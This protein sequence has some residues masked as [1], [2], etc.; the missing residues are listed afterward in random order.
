[1][2]DATKLDILGI[3]D[4]DLSH[5]LDINVFIQ[6]STH[7]TGH[8]KSEMVYETGLVTLLTGHLT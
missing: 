2:G 7:E 1:M 4:F 6:I 8:G 5:D 3:F